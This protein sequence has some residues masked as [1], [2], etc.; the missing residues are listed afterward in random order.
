MK[1]EEQLHKVPILALILSY[2]HTR[3]ALAVGEVLSRSNSTFVSARLT[4][5]FGL[6]AELVV[7][8]SSLRHS[9]RHHEAWRGST[10][11]VRPTARAKTRR[12]PVDADD[13]AALAVWQPGQQQIALKAWDEGE[14]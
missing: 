4:P 6:R 2:Q 3:P 1:T 13:D 9:A 11:A 7:A 12:T 5:N 10:P 14:A 8:G